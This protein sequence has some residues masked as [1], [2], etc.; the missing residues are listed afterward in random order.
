VDCAGHLA[1]AA[2]AAARDAVRPGLT[3]SEIDAIRDGEVTD[4]QDRVVVRAVDELDKR[5]TI[6]DPTWAELGGHFD[7]RQRM[8][9]VFTVGCYCS[10][11]MA[12]NT[13]GIEDEDP[14]G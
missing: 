1:H 3:A 13:F 14:D 6:S 9:L 2:D 4:D 12:V 5:S 11:A 7:D 8:D 10:L